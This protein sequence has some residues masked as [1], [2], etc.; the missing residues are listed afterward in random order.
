MHVA[1]LIDS[2]HWGGAQKLLLTFSETSSAFGLTTTVISLSAPR[3]D[4]TLPEEIKTQEVE[5]VFMPGPRLFDPGRFL[6]LSRYLKTHQV[7]V[8]HTHLTYANILGPWAG[9]VAR[10]PVIS[11]LHNERYPQSDHKIRRWLETMSLKA[12]SHQII[13]IGYAVQAAQRERFPHRE[14]P[15]IL[16][17]LTPLP[18]ISPR[19]R[20]QLRNSILGDKQG[21]LLISVGH[22]ID[23][24]GFEHLITVV[25]H[26]KSQIPEIV[27]I[28]AGE[29][30]LRAKLEKE[31][32]AAGL[33]GS[34]QLL[35]HRNDVPALL[36]S[37]DLY[38]NSSLWEG[39]PISV[40]EAMS[41][42]LP[43]VATRVGDIPRVV[44]PEAGVLIPPGDEIR[45][46]TAILDMLSNPHQMKKMGR[47]A[48][49]VVSE[50]FSAETWVKQLK[51]QYQLVSNNRVG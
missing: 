7:D 47:A 25:K 13:A 23:Q 10:V 5:V 2:L 29:G 39:L 32:S 18:E 33:V 50:H 4:I 3:Q 42:G 45:L 36:A 27:V 12:A 16:N 41:A 8:M 17:A 34:I 49:K 28:I 22:L 15:V 19:E 51:D 26:I 6:C 38:V 37:S 35:G 20:Q 31:I 14:L 24:K 30:G 48:R 46:K 9:R 44:P 11:S 1:Q 21:P 40:L 43:I